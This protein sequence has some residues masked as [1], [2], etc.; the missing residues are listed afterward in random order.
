MKS[1]ILSDKKGIGLDEAIPLIVFIIT[2]AITIVVFSLVNSSITEAI[3]NEAGLWKQQ[4]EGRENLFTFL[5]QETNGKQNALHLIEYYHDRKNEAT[6]TQTIEGFF[7]KKYSNSWLFIV[8]DA[9]NNK[10]L[11]EGSDTFSR[12]HLATIHL[13]LLTSTTPYLKITLLHVP[14]DISAYP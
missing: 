2:A 4:V 10:I 12:A 11:D 13:P 1:K 9:Q 7:T 3:Q 5:T 6:I 14:E 8:E